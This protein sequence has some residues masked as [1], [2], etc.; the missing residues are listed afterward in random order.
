M[1]EKELLKEIN[2][3]QDQISANEL[4]SR[5][6]RES[7]WDILVSWW[8]NWPEWT[9]PSKEFLPGNGTNGIMIQKN[10]TPIVAG[11][12]YNTVDSKVVLLEWIISNPK[13]R[14]DDRQKAIELLITEVENKSKA[15]GYK[16]VFTIGRSKSLINTHKKLGWFVDDKPS[17]EIT[18]ILK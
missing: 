1:N 12:M 11:F 10:G 15:L 9:A 6:L 2:D 16:Y 7:D 14:E 3:L 5:N 17:H 4:V 13:Y 18:K 8:A